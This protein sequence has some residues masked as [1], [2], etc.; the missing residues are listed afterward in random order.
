MNIEWNKVTWYSKL[1]AVIFFLGVLPVLTFYI[2]TQYGEVLTIYENPI[3]TPVFTS[4]DTISSKDAAMGIINTCPNQTTLGLAGC[5]GQDFSVSDKELEVEFNKIVANF[6]TIVSKHDTESHA[7]SVVKASL[8]KAEKGW[9]SYRDSFCVAQTG[10]DI[11]DANG[12]R[13]TGTNSLVTYPICLSVLTKN[14]IKDLHDFY[15]AWWK[16]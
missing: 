16:Q 3:I 6:D 5:A 13:L 9:V 1:A 4:V 10:V 14:H 2:G 8:V 7:Y 12:S 15:D 11:E